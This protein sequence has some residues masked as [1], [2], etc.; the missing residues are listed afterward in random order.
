MGSTR[1][2]TDQSIASTNMTAAKTV[3]IIGATGKSG[4]WAMKGALQRGYTVRVL[5]RNPDKVKT[6]MV[7]L[8]GEEEADAQLAKVTVVKGGIMDEAAVLDLF[9]GACCSSISR[10]GATSN[11]SCL[12]RSG[13]NG[14]SNEEDC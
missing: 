14:K 8:F 5:A 9:R 1:S 3:S 13:G 11:L 4:M 10:N 2:H 7:T 12:S 6:I